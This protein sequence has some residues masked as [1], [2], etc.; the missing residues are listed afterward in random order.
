[1]DKVVQ[2]TVMCKNY[3]DT[4]WNIPNTTFEKIWPKKP[5]INF[6]NQEMYGIL[7][8]RGIKSKH[9]NWI[10]DE[11]IKKKVNF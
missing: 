6:D 2:R 7:F 1:M 9:E 11:F 5:V 8:Y 4:E 10:H 3:T